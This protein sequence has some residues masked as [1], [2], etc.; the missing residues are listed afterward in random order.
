MR[1]TKGFSEFEFLGLIAGGLLIAGLLAHFVFD[2]SIQVERLKALVQRDVVRLN[3]ETKL[4]DVEVMKKSAQTLVD[5]EE[6][7]SLR[8]CILGDAGNGFC[9]K[10]ETCCTSRMR[11]SIPIYQLGETP[12]MIAGTTSQSACLNQFGQPTT[13]D[14]F[15]AV[16]SSLETVCAVGETSCRSAS[17]VIIRYQI[18]FLPAFLRAEPELSILERSVSLI[19]Q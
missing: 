4:L 12:Q 18:Q 3:L 10:K 14:C 6:N 5:N 17:A 19:L 7:A 11:K 16:T 2:Q 15:A 8:A 13:S 1:N 9:K